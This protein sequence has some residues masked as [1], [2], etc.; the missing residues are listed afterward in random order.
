MIKYWKNQILNL[1]VWAI[2]KIMS[3]IWEKK[4]W[5]ELKST[6]ITNKELVK[7]LIILWDWYI[8]T[9]ETLLNFFRILKNNEGINELFN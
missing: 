9:E 4:Y 6:E 5:K 3:V 7:F 2:C 1:K 8:F